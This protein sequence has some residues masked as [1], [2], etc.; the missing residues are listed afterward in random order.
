MDSH[1]TT[2]VNYLRYGALLVHR[3]F[4][5][6]TARQTLP[7][8][9]Q[10]GNEAVPWTQ[11]MLSLHTGWS[12]WLQ[13]FPRHNSKT[14]ACTY[15]SEYYKVYSNFDEAYSHLYTGL[16]ILLL[17]PSMF[18]TWFIQPYTTTTKIMSHAWDA[19]LVWGPSS[20]EPWCRTPFEEAND[21]RAG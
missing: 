13:P 21:L 10:K 4:A 20:R 3:S 15:D 17:I 18:I 7:K 12:V 9:H 8:L 16:Q 19:C 2:K 6:T 14:A 11:I 5:I 1:V